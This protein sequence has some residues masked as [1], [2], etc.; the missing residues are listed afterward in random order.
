[1][2]KRKQKQAQLGDLFVQLGTIKSTWEVVSLLD[3]PYLPPHF[4]IM[5]IKGQ[6]VKLVAQSVLLDKAFF[7]PTEPN[8]TFVKPTE[9]NRTF[10][11]P[12][13]KKSETIPPSEYRAKDRI[14]SLFGQQ[15]RQT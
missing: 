11:K 14:T 4:R 10:V 1:M 8:R 13:E 12:A 5:E 3:N 6:E 7:E 2:F 9:P 15:T